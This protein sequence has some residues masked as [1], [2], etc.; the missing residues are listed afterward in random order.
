[1]TIHYLLTPF[2]K[3]LCP[4]FYELRKL[5]KTW[6]KMTFFFMEWVTSESYFIQTLL[7]T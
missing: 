2:K 7:M 5:K 6:D 4:K 3:S 1:M